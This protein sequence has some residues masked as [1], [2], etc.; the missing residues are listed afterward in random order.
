M[1]DALKYDC[2]FL[3][4]IYMALPSKHQTRWLDYEKSTCHWD[5]MM[6]F[7]DRVYDQANAELALISSYESDHKNHKNLEEK[8]SLLKPRS[9]SFSYK[10]PI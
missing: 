7:L 3:S 9:I 5:D 10:Y 2:E 8:L 1:N 4:A 6:K